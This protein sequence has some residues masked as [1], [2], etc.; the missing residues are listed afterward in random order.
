MAVKTKVSTKFAFK[1]W[2]KNLA[3]ELALIV[4]DED[5]QWVANQQPQEVNLDNREEVKLD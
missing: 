2:A 5:I 4:P 3:K 1:D